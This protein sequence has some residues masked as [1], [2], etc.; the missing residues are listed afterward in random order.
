[1]PTG[2]SH[3]GDIGRVESFRRP[4]RFARAASAG[5]LIGCLG[6]ASMGAV[7]QSAPA[8]GPPS[9]AACAGCHGANGEGAGAFP[10]LAGAGAPYLR[11]QLEAFASG[12]R[13]SPV[14][15]PIAQALTAPQ[16]DELAAF[17]AAKTKLGAAQDVEPRTSADVG[18]WLA[19][20]GRWQDDLP[21]CAQC[22]GPG[23][24]GVGGHFPPLAGQPAAYLEQ[25][26]RAWRTDDRPPGPLGLMQIVARKLSDA[27]VKA[28]SDYY[29]ALQAMPAAAP[30]RPARKGA[31]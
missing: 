30:A 6:L 9:A 2:P 24:I 7:G 16:R 8:A 28:V 15:Q 10:R 11:E 12:K 26:L 20:R 22:H 5:L 19:T 23:G 31:P 18:P 27:E 14:M 17:Y 25:Q 13:K 21:A 3:L 1:M 29:A 4:V